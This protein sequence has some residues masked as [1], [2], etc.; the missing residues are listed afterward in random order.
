M[1]LVILPDQYTQYKMKNVI[2]GRIQSC[3]L[4]SVLERF[5]EAWMVNSEP[6]MESG[7]F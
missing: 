2:G 3:P 1:T 5:L 6:I 7:R 4:K